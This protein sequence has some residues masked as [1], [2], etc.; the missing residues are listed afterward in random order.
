MDAKLAGNQCT[1]K[2]MECMH[3]EKNIDIDL[4]IVTGQDASLEMAMQ[5]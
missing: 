3:Q 5:Y 1:L 4:I 2:G